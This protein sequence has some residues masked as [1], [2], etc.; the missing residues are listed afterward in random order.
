MA[1]YIVNKIKSME[2]SKYDEKGYH[3][4]ISKNGEVPKECIYRSGDDY[5]TE[6]NF[7]KNKQVAISESVKAQMTAYGAEMK[8]TASNAMLLMEGFRY[9]A[10]EG[11]PLIWRLYGY[12]EKLP[13]YEFFCFDNDGNYWYILDS[14]SDFFNKFCFESYSAK[15][16]AENSNIEYFSKNKDTLPLIDCAERAGDNYL[17]GELKWLLGLATIKDVEYLT[18]VDNLARFVAEEGVYDSN[19]IAVKNAK[20]CHHGTQIRGI[21]RYYSLSCIIDGKPYMVEW[22]EKYPDK[23]AVLSYNRSSKITISQDVVEQI[24]SK[25]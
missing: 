12:K 21:K 2:L 14:V 6:I 7:E 1:D 9:S 22:Q 8:Q 16:M 23:L 5:Y 3:Y 20:L 13:V 4:Y 18:S 25:L 11:K 19:R 17:A 24:K 10:F 15:A